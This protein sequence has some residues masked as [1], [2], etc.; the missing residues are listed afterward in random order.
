MKKCSF[1]SFADT[2][3]CECCARLSEFETHEE[4]DVCSS[5]N[6][7]RKESASNGLHCSSR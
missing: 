5:A 6:I 4:K 2:K 3:R 7:E 1:L